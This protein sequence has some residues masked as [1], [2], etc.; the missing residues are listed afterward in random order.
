MSRLLTAP[1]FIL[2]SVRSGSTL[3]RVLLDSHSQIHAPPE[4]HLRGMRVR[5][6]GRYS[7]RSLNAIGLDRRE[8]RHLLWDRV[9]HR[10]LERS[11]KAI[12]VNKTPSDV[13]IADRIRECWPDAR[14]VFLLRHPLAIVRSRA[15]ARG[16][17]NEPDRNLRRVLRYGAALE[18]ARARHPGPTL[19]YEDLTRDPAGETRRVCEF[20]GVPWEPAMLDYGRREHGAFRPGLGDWSENIR[21]GSVQ[22]AAPLPA[23][24]EVPAALRELCAAWGYLPQAQQALSP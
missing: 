13:F 9:L 15:A 20:L 14:F 2:C 19:R 5:V 8:L 4:L 17:A 12:L 23:A 7:Q 11:D 18:A 22:P 6:R 21:S 3:L 24:E 10:E 1:V 16:K